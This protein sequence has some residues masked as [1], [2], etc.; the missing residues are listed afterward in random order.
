MESINGPDKEL[1][2]EALEWA[3]GVVKKMMSGF[4]DLEGKVH[5]KIQSQ[6]GGDARRQYG[7]LKAVGWFDKH[8]MDSPNT[9]EDLTM[10]LAI[11]KYKALEWSKNHP[12][13]KKLSKW[14]FVTGKKRK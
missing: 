5:A 9:K 10:I 3:D 12:P 14:E 13:K 4:R 1:V 11:G 2:A 7:V 8:P 6:I